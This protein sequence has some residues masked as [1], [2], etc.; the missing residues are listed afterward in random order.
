VKQNKSL[1]VR[2]KVR[3]GEDSKGNRDILKGKG[4]KKRR[5]EVIFT[6]TTG[7]YSFID[8]R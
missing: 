7:G 8:N 3:R 5:Y 1:V 4:R 2:W 6:T